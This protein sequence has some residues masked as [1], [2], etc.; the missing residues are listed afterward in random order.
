MA[1]SDQRE[2][3]DISHDESVRDTHRVV[4]LTTVHD[5]R[6]PRIFHKQLKTLRAA[7]YDARIVAPRDGSASVDGI[8][9]AAL[10]EVEGRYQRLVLQRVVYQQARKLNAD[11]Y[12]FHDPELIPLAY[13]LKRETG[14]RIIYDMHEDYRWHGP[15]EGRL[16][17]MLERWCFRWVDHV[18]LAESSYRIIVAG[19]GVA[20]TFIGNYMRVHD[21]APPPPS[22]DPGDPFRLLYTGIVSESRGLGYMIDLMHCL[23]TAGMDAALDVVGVC[24]FADQRQR[25]VRDIDRRDLGRHIRRRGWDS[26]VPVAAM[27]PYYQ[28]ADV[29]LALFDPDPNYVQSTPTKFFEYLHFGLPILC[30]DFPRWRRFIERHDCGAVVPPGDADAA[31]QVV[32]CWHNNPDRYRTLSAAAR[33]AAP[34]YRWEIMGKRLVRL[35][36]ALLGVGPISE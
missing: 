36:D 2:A 4:H 35:Y 17:R 3:V 10:P 16:I 25:A 7:G 19:S 6:D 31:L 9:I 34:Q 26:Y 32:R 21:D 5:P 20:S 11:L 14:A 8:P 12:H 33:A 22:N 1:R 27:T 13:V 18:I 29:G 24:N 28:A 23:R 30:S 15:V